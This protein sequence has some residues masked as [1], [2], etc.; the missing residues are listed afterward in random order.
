[1][2]GASLLP[3][4]VIVTTWRSLLLATTPE[5]SVPFS[6]YFRTSVSPAARKLN[7]PSPLEPEVKVQA[8]SLPA[9]GSA[10]SADVG[11][12]AII[13]FSAV[14]L[15]GLVPPNV[16]DTSTATL[17]TVTVTVSLRSA[18]TTLS[19]PVA[20]S[21]VSVSVFAAEIAVPVMSGASLLPVIVIVT[22][23]LSL[24]LATTPEESVPFSV[25]F[26]TSVSP[27]ARKLNAPSPLEPEVKVQAKSLPAV[28][29]AASADV[30][31][32]AIIAFSAVALSGLV[33]PNVLDTSTATLSTVTVTVSLRSA[34]TT[35]SV[36]VAV[37]VVS[38]SVFAA[39]IAVPVMSGASLLPVIVIVTTWLSLLLAT[40]P[41]E[42][43][44]FSVYFRT[45]VSPAARKLNAPSPLEPEVKVQAK[46]LPAVGSAASAD[47]GDTAI[48]A[49]SAVALSGLVPPNV[50]DTSTATLSTV[51]VTVSLRS[52][53]TTLS[54]PV[55]VSVVSVSVFAAEI[56]VPVMSGASLLP[57]IVI[58]T[59]WLSLL[60]AT[61]P[62]ESVPFSVYF[63]TSVSPA[64]RKLNAPSP[65][66]PEVKVQAKSL[67]AVGSAASADVGDTAIIAF[68][69]VALSG[70]VPPNVLDTSTATLSTVTVT[71]SLRS[72]STTL[73]VPVAVS[74]VSVSVFAA[75]IAVPVMSGAS[76]LPVIVIVTT[77]LSLLLATT[78]EES[79][80]FSVYF[81]T[82]VSPAARKLNAPSPLEPEVKVQAK[83]LPA[84]G[85]A[86]SADVGDTAII[87][88]SAVALSGLVPPNVLDT[89]T[90]TLSTVTVTV[91][92]RS[93]STTL[94]VPVAVSVVSVSV[95]AAEIAVPV[96]S[97]ASLLPVIV[98]VTTWLSLLLATT[99]EES[100]PFSVYFRTSVSPAA[101]KL[102][103]PS[104][105]EPEVKVQAK[106]LPAVGSAASA[107]VGDTAI[108]AFSA[109]ALSGLVPP[110][111]LDTSTATLSTVTVTVSLRSAST[112][113]SVPVAVSVVSVSVFAAEIA[114]PVMSGASLLPV[115]VIVT[116]WL[117]LLLA[118]TPEE[119]VPFSVY[120]RTSVSPAAR[121]LN[122]PS[123]L[124]PEVKVQAK[125][126]PAVG[127]AASADVGD[128]A[129][130]AFSAVAL[131]GLVPPNV[132]DTSTATL[133]TVTVTVSLR[134]ASTTLSV[135]VA[136]SV[137]SVS[138]FAAEIAV[139]VMS[140]ASLLPVI[141]IVTVCV[142]DSGDALL[143]V[144]FTV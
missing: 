19:V 1:M 24:L 53:S 71:V 73:S 49:F 52:A 11:D 13:A 80:P 92:L 21:V 98:I 141:V 118:T 94:S 46:S 5:E 142:S 39:E 122:A 137:V 78:P 116:T 109:V 129:I 128:T 83:S 135:P 112:T 91:S 130:I 121:K 2:S 90:A 124:E 119:S 54:V 100:V 4:I 8:K 74:V 58:V 30:G 18:S 14:A 68:S 134:S 3:V 139:P 106:S 36:P 103:A 42:S 25:Y 59:T 41:E 115:I 10:A 72:A 15:S 66:E 9:V 82:S 17:S 47:V 105:L 95:F 127:S 62:E 22:T 26:R 28:G 132:L 123:P 56:A 44:P 120:F 89:S 63:R 126:L 101:R 77:W 31:D 32:T 88:F 67:P 35:L 65:L 79:V 7:A 57:V 108:I 117:S 33:P 6:V 38:V 34:S 76:L 20:V 125:S 96:M 113:L 138:V 43:V 16:L 70:L 99:P 69:A 107:D 81:R 29:S 12:T 60:L 133:S 87:A 136:V 140:G 111:V 84:V 61:T 102:N 86:A 23:W 144:L 97:G 37:S 104:P 114:V 48:I 143:S 64:A 131:S 27:A 50:L 85:S 75:E 40:T 51:T 45:S 110:N 93:A 55:A